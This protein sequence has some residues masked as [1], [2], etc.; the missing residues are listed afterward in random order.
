[1]TFFQFLQRNLRWV[2]G[3]FLLGFGSS[4]GQTFFIAQFS[5]QIR[6]TYNL[7]HGDFGSIY[8][9]ATLASA[10]TLIYL[11][12]VVDYYRP[13]VVGCAA[14]VI[15]AGFSFLMSWHNS[16]ILLAI[17]LYGLRLFGQGMLPHTSQTAMSRWF[18]GSRGKALSLASFGNM[19]GEALLPLAAVSLMALLSWRDLWS[20]AGVTLL[21][22]FLP[23]AYLTL[24]KDR[25]PENP[26]ASSK[27]NGPAVS[28]TRKQVMS[29]WRF[30]VVITA[31]LTVPFLVTGLMFHQVHFMEAKGWE[32]TVI[33]SYLPLYAAAG[34][35]FSMLTGMLID[36]FSAVSL[37]PLCVIPLG[38]SMLVFAFGREEYS[39][40]V[41]MVIL[42]ITVGSWGALASAVLA[43]L[44]GTAH[45]GSIRAVYTAMMVF[46]SALAPGL[47]GVLLDNGIGLD[48]QFAFSSLYCFG[49]GLMLFAVKPQLMLVRSPA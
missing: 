30:W 46:A 44:Y 12:R 22:C 16:I 21:V 31:V 43:E 41:A 10:A 15:L 45:L 9:F 47:M 8:M 28:W 29:D 35:V 39:V 42:A 5:S 38:I 1:M 11:G 25:T 48:T 17:C 49:L 27:T 33:P 32:R 3:G 23:L 34:A 24:K 26:L 2:A 7:S 6:E 14:I 36:R 13:V 4:F 19:A 20:A 18:H 37:L 40:P